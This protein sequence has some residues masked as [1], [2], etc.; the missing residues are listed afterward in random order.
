[1]SFNSFLNRGAPPKV[2]ASE[3]YVPIPYPKWIT[4][5][6]GKKI[7]VDSEEAERAALMPPPIPTEKRET[8][9]LPTK[10]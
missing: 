10:E 4:L 8:L 5:E 1:M 7:I 6:D 3:P 9:R 2:G